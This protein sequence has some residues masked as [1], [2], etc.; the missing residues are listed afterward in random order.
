MK[1]GPIE[2]LRSAIALSP[3]TPT[4]L[5]TAAGLGLDTVS[6]WLSGQ[7]VP[8]TAQLE[9]ALNTLGYRLTVEPIPKEE[10]R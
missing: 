10:R 4:T 6:R 8:S 7:R 9:R 3:Y 2:F 1:P 5:S